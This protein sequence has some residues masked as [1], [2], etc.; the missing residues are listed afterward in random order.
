[1]KPTTT[2]SGRFTRTMGPGGAC[3]RSQLARVGMQRRTALLAWGA[4]AGLGR[5][6]LKFIYSR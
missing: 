3:M 5:N 4:G 2:L 1:M 6:G